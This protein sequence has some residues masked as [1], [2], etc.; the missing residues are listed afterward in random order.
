VIEIVVLFDP[1]QPKG[2]GDKTVKGKSLLTRIVALV[3]IALAF[4][5]S[6]GNSYANTPNTPPSVSIIWPDGTFQPA[7]DYQPDFVGPEYRANPPR[8]SAGDTY[9]QD[10]VVIRFRPGVPIEQ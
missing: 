5:P 7:P 10:E 2:K 6:A 9:A 4:A 8:Y 1:P 3:V